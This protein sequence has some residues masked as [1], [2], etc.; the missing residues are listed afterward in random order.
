MLYTVGNGAAGNVEAFVSGCLELSSESRRGPLLQSMVLIRIRPGRKS[1]TDRRIV[2]TMAHTS[3]IR[4]FKDMRLYDR[5]NKRKREIS[6]IVDLQLESPPPKDACSMLPANS[7]LN[8]GGRTVKEK[9]SSEASEELDVPAYVPSPQEVSRPRYLCLWTHAAGRPPA[10]RAAG[11]AQ[12]S[13]ASSGTPRNFPSSTIS[14]PP[15]TDEARVHKRAMPA[16]ACIV[17]APLPRASSTARNTIERR[18]PSTCPHSNRVFQIPVGGGSA[19]KAREEAC[20]RGASEDRHARSADGE[21]K[22]RRGGA[23]RW[24]REAAYDESENQAQYEARRV[25][26]TQSMVT[27]GVSKEKSSKSGRVLEAGDGGEWSRC[28]F[29]SARVCEQLRNGAGESVVAD[30]GAVTMMLGVESRATC[31]AGAGQGAGLGDIGV[32]RGGSGTNAASGDTVLVGFGKRCEGHEGKGKE[33][34]IQEE[35]IPGFE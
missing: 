16:L 27:A 18:S 8:T 4:K 10:L 9:I 15:R 32:A 3:I 1:S 23:G 17:I 6:E 12:I 20:G 5:V 13:N 7:S 28:V 21:H 29:Q 34:Q 24:A 14:H 2:E 19:Q 11:S 33:C 31:G 22:A 30:G 35:T 25:R 26:D